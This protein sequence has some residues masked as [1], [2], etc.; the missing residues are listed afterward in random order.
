MGTIE[1]ILEEVYIQAM[2]CK[3]WAVVRQVAGLL[4]KVR[5]SADPV[6]F[7]LMNH[8]TG[9]QLFDYQCGGPPYSWKGRKDLLHILLWKLYST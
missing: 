1:S 6:R 9:R 5:L 7:A 8:N 4:R 3:E 2:A